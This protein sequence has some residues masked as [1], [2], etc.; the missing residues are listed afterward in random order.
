[1]L[2]SSILGL[3][4]HWMDYSSMY[5]KGLSFEI[6]SS[7]FAHNKWWYQLVAAPSIPQCICSLH[8]GCSHLVGASSYRFSHGRR[9]ADQQHGKKKVIV[10]PNSW[11][12]M[13]LELPHENTGFEALHFHGEV[14]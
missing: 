1:M 14:E 5:I 8:H 9:Q 3:I 10:W 11:R 4:N 12:E 2:E 7:W 6:L 13:L